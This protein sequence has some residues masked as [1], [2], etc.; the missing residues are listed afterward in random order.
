MGAVSD[1]MMPAFL[2]VGDCGIRVCFGEEIHLGIHRRVR[3]FCRRLEF[4]RPDG[5]REWV[6]GYAI[7][8]IYY[9]PWVSSFEALCETLVRLSRRRVPGAE[10]TGGRLK[11]IPVC[12]GG[13]FGPDLADIAAMHGLTPAQVIRRHCR[14]RYLVYF[15]G[16]Q[17]GFPYLGGLPPSLATPR[18]ASPRASV[19]AGSVGIAGS[20]TGVYP[21]ATPG[22]WQIIGRTPLRLFDPARQPLALLT[23]GDRVKFV[24]ITVQEYEEAIH[25]PH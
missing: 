10:W 23:P 22:G 19:P 3:A 18:Q 24:P 1:G 11:E 15:L 20:Q 8:T 14:P 6:P 12:Y 25:A 4:F 21:L 9:Q 17:P 16:F 7:V 2:P 13:E 5:V